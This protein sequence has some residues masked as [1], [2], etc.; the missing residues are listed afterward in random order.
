M[1]VL[2][3]LWLLLLVILGSGLAVSLISFIGTSARGE[4]GQALL[5][6]WITG[7]LG[8]AFWGVCSVAFSS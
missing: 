2:G 7:V 8:L 5:S 6:F 1:S 3:P 4:I